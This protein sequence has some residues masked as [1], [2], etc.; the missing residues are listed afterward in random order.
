MP[1]GLTLGMGT[2][3]AGIAAGG[4]TVYGATKQAGAAKRAGDLQS[5]A[6]DRALEYEKQQDAIKNAQYLEERGRSWRNEDEDRMLSRARY[7]AREERLSPYR[8]LG[9]QSVATLAR[10]LGSGS[11]DDYKVQMPPPPAVPPRNVADL[12]ARGA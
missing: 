5:R 10:L 4:A 6:A 2:A 12:A 3:I 1:V 9:S 7:D 11:G 8:D